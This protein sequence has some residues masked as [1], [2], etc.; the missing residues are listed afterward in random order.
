MG[1]HQQTS[2]IDVLKKYLPVLISPIITAAVVLT[3]F[4]SRGLY[5]FGS[6]TASWCDMNQQVVPLLCQ[7][8]DILDGKSGMFLSFKN[9]SG[10]NFWGVFFF[11]LA[12]PFTLLVKFV[13]KGDILVFA[14]ILIVLKMSLCAACASLYFCRSREFERL[15]AVSRVTLGVIYAASGYTMLFYQNI[16][17][18]DVMY[19]FPCLMLSLERLGG[20]RGSPLPYAVVLAL[21]AA[22][23]YYIAYMLVLFLLIIMGLC[24]VYSLRGEKIER[25]FFLRF[26]AGSALAA[27][28]SAVVWL[29]SFIQ[30]LSSGRRDSLIENLRKGHFITDYDTTLPVIMCSGLLVLLAWLGCR[31]PAPELRR[32]IIKISALLL[33]I[34]I[35]IEPINKMWHTGSYMAFPARYA[36]MSIFMLMLL[37]G[38]ELSV[39]TEYNNKMWQYAA[40]A[41]SCAVLLLGFMLSSKKYVEDFGET[42][43]DYTR[44]LGGTEG[45]F[46]GLAKL[47]IAAM[48]CAGVIFLFY[49]KGWI[50]KEV[51][52]VL[53]AI[54]TVIESANF[55]TVYMTYSAERNEATNAVQREI[56]DLGGKI[57]DD[58]FY[59]VKTNA[60]IFDYNTI[61]AM[62]YNSI[63]HYTS[64]TAEDYM[65]TM[66]RLGYTSVWMEVG[67]CGGTE[68]T[69]AAMSI[70]YRISNVPDPD[71]FYNDMGYHI[72]KLEN[73]LPIGFVP[74]ADLSENI[75]KG[76]DRF[77]VQ[78]YI[79]Q[80]I[81][82][83]PDIVESY[84]PYKGTPERSG[85]NTLVRV[86]REYLYSIPV[87]GSKTLYFDC[88]DE[89]TNELTEPIYGS[90]I[91]E[92]NGDTLTANYPYGKENGVL[93]LGT[94]TDEI[95]EI[96]LR[97]KKTID[98]SSF[99]VF[100]VDL[101]KLSQAAANVTSA[102]LTEVKNGLQ[103]SFSS[104]KAQTLLLSLPYDKGLSIKVN[105]K[106]VPA[107]RALSAFTEFDLPAGNSEISISFR[108]VGFT[109]GATVSLLG[110]IAAAAL[111]LLLRRSSRIQNSS[112]LSEPSRADRFC[113]A[114]FAAAG[115]AVLLVIYI[116]PVVLNVFFWKPDQ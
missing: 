2:M 26:T 106:A 45:S 7:F 43:S 46:K 115:G 99:G 110:I 34:P 76:L 37:A 96:S 18:L 11:F 8:K 27:A 21:M 20:K 40:A 48:I 114:L 39:K 72:T 79:A 82:G 31:R 86:N 1:S 67:S 58:G 83:D 6:R 109:A 59:R 101:D 41:I 71:S 33:L 17:W 95:V 80:N 90:F 44:S 51:T 29:P 105:G 88:F 89:L 111:A 100:S 70:G 54:L 87:K 19:L 32:R 9:A 35:F 104:D 78:R 65:F 4:R 63:A 5:P 103:G 3:V 42:L 69:D 61:G 77:G 22:V 113:R 62:G 52:M 38:Y 10:M 12:S 116:L 84:K 97:A 23:N 108:P 15:D 73:K 55:T 81:F 24:A 13:D 68:L 28:M 49:R 53:F 57:P 25:G 30:Y 74:A 102:Q 14:D 60:K 98:M 66:K 91:V 107:R 56:L 93:K 47:F 36:F 16:I 64:L 112:P 75:P 92:V 85:G 94:F 50:F